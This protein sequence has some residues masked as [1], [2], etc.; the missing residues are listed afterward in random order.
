MTFFRKARRGTPT[1]ILVNLC[2]SLIALN[3]VLY[4]AERYGGTK[5]G[6]RISNVFRY[7]FIL[8]SLLWNGVEAHNMYRML[9][10]VFNTGGQSHFVLKAAIVAWG[11]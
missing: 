3:I 7:Y 2:V 4:I 10:K 11:Q 1:R 6:C 8:V 9:I 5:L